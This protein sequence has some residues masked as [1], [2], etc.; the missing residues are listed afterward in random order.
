MADFFSLRLLWHCPSGE[1][2]AQSS[3][4]K[5]IAQAASQAQQNKA[6]A[7]D[8]PKKNAKLPAAPLIGARLANAQYNFSF[9]PSA[10]KGVTL[11][12]PTSLQFGP[13]GHLYVSQQNGLIKDLTIRRNA[14]ND[15]TVTSSKDIDLINLIPNHDDNGQANPGVTVRQ[16][17][18]ILVKGTAS[19]P[20]IYVS[21]SDSRV[22]GPG[23]DLNLDTN[24]GIVSKLTRSGTTWSKVDLVRGLPRSEENHA[25]NGMQLD[26]N[27]LYLAVGGHTN[28]GSPSVNFAFTPEYALSA[29]ILSIDLDAIS[30][31][32]VKGTGN[33]SYIYDLPTLDDPDRANLADG[34]DPFD[35]FGGNDG[36][37]QAKIVVGGPVQI[38]SPGYRN[39]YD[40]VITRARRMY[41]ID[42]GANQYWGGYPENEGGGNATN[43]YVN[44]EPGSSGPTATEDIVN[45]LDNLHYIGDLA[46]YTAGSY[47]GGHPAPT[48]ANPTNAGLYTHDGT[49]GVFRISKIGPNPLPADWPPVSKANPIEGDY[50][51]PGSA[52]S[53]SLLTFES[54]TNGLCEYTA[55]NFGGALQ[56]S[57][58]ACSFNGDIVKISLT[59]DGTNVT[60]PYNPANKV[61]SDLPFASGFGSTPL[62]ITAQGDGEIFAGSVWAATYG[63]SAI[64]IFEPQDFLTCSGAYNS[65]DDDQDGYTNADEID[66]GTQP[67][68]AASRPTDSNNNNISDLNDNDDD[69]DGLAD[70]KDFFALDKDN[71]LS[72]NLPIKYELL[73]NGPGGLFTVG[74]TGLMSNGDSTYS[75]LYTYGDIIGGGTAGIFTVVKVTA[76]DALGNLNTQENGFQVGIKSTGSPFT[77]QG[78]MLGP[79]FNDKVPQGFQSQG[80]YLGTGD[81]DNYLKIALAANG[82]TGGLQIVHENAGVPVTTNFVLPGGVPST[83][84][85][86]FFSVNPAAGTVQPK[87]AIN[88]SNTVTNLGSPIQLSGALLATVQSGKAYAVGLIATSRGASIFGAGWDFIY[89]T[90]DQV[91]ALGTWSPVTPTTGAFT[92]RQENAYVGAGNKFYLLGGRGTLPVQEYNPAAKAWATKAAP[93]VELSHFQAVTLD[94]LIYAMGAMNG[95]Y[96]REVPVPNV[97]IYNPTSDKW[98]VGGTIPQA[99][100][101]GS[102]GTVTYKNKIYMVGGIIDGHWAGWVPWFDEYDPATNT[103]KALPNAPR[104]RDHFNATIIDDKLYLVGGR[105]SSVSTNQP[106][107]LTVPEVDV[108]DFTTGQWAT[109]PSA[110]NLPT[111]RAGAATAVLGTELLVIGGESSLAAAHK[112]THS[113]D[114]TTNT[115]RR[116]ADLQTGRHSTQAIVNN[117]GVYLAAGATTQGGT[118]LASTQEAFYFF[119]PTTPGGTALAPSKLTAVAT[120]DYGFPAPNTDSTR[121]VK[122]TNTDG[123]QAILVSAV[124]LSGSSSFSYTTPSIL[125]VVV[126]VGKT[127]DV[128][129]KFNTAVG[130]TQTAKLVVSHSGVGDTTVTAIKGGGRTSPLFRVR[131][132]GDALTTSIGAFSAD[133]NFNGNGNTYY[134]GNQIGGTED[135]ALYQ[136]ERYGTAFGYAFPV[137]SGQQYRV[138]L[139]FAE[140]YATTIGQRVFDVSLEG[141][142]VLDNYDIFK[143]VGTNVAT[144][145]TFT[146]TVADDVLNLNF[147]SLAADGGVDN[148]K[149]SAIEVYR[150]SQGSNQPPVANAGPDK[151]VSLPATST[152]LS[153]SGTD[154]DGTITTYAWTQ[155]SGPNT[156]IFS[157]KNAAAPTLN[158][159][160]AGSYVFSLIVTDNE[161]QASTADQ[162]T[163]KVNPAPAGVAAIYR[164]HAGGPA[165]STSIGAFDSDQY[166]SGG[167]AAD[168]GN[169]IAGTTDDALYQTER[170]GAM[171][172]ALPVSNG[173]YTVKLHFAEV[174]WSAPGQR[175]FDVTAEGTKVLSAYDI[176]KKVGQ[177]TATTETFTATVTDG[178]L[179]LVFAKGATGADEPKVSAIEVLTTGTANAAPVANAGPDKST[180][181]PTNSVILNGSGTDSDGTVASYAWTQVS[182]PNTAVFSSKTVA[183]PTVSGLIA[184]NYVFSLIVTDNAG[185]ASTADQVAVTVS[186]AANAAPVANAGP[187]KTVTLP[188]NTTTLAGSGTD[189]DGSITTYAWTQVSGP[190]TATFSSTTIAAPTVSGL[191]AGAYVFSLIVTDNAGLASTA[192]QV[193]I[194]VNS[195]ANAAP[196]ANAGPDKT[197]TLPTN[198]VLLTGSGTDADGSV[199]TYAWTQ[200]S[201][202]NTAVFTSKTVAQPTVSG[203]VAGPYVFSLIVTDNAG[204]ASTADQVTVTVNSVA[205]AAP[206]A[207]AGAD[208]T[209]TL[210]TN[211]TTLNGSGT[212]SDGSIT[213]YAWTQ[214]SGPNTAVFSS[215][216]VAAP[217]VSG[218]VAGAY[219]FSLVVTDNAGLASTADQ[220]T[221]TVNSVAN[222]TPVAN[223]GPDKAITLPTNSTTLN[224]S[225]TDDGT[226]TTYAWTQVSGPNTAVFTSKATAAPTVS[227][228]IAGNYV[229]SLVV[230]DNAGLA[231]A[232]DQVNVTVSPAPTGGGTPVYRINAGGPAVT[233][234]GM[235]FAADN[236]YVSGGF[237]SGGGSAIAGTV[238][239]VLYQTERWGTMSYNLPVTNG[240][241]TVKLHFA[242]VYWGGAGQRVFDVSAEGTK[243]L[244]AYDIFKKV[245]QNTATIETLTVTVTD[246]TLNIAFAKGATGA[247]EPKVSA[248]EVLTTTGP[249]NTAP[250]ANAGPDKTITLPTSNVTLTGSGTDA[251][252]NPITYAWTQVSG[253]STAVFTSK[254]V[255]QPAVSNLVAG[256]YVFS[257]IVTDNAGLASPADQVTVTVNAA[258]NVMPVANAGPDKVITLPTSSTVL[259]G[260]GT[261]SDGSVTTYAWTQVSGPNTA[262]FT[263]KATAAPTVSGLVAGNYVFSLVVTDNAGLASA[264]D[265]VNVTVSPAP[266]G[267]GTPVYRINAGGPA[268]TTSGMAFA[269]DNQYVSGGFPS[270]GGSAIA[271]TV[272]DVLYQT[273]RWGTMS[274][275]LPVTNGTYTVKLHFAEVYW[276]G[277]GQ[278]VFDVS[279]EGTKVLTAYDIFKKVGQNT[280]TIETLTVTVTDGTLNIAFAKGATGA[281]EPK[282]SAIE[283]LTTTS[284]AA[285]TSAGT[286]SGTLANASTAQA[287][288][289]QGTTV[290]NLSELVEV[291]PNPSTDGRYQVQ[292]PAAFQGE[293]SYSLISAQGQLVRQG[294]VTPTGSTLVLDFS[295][296]MPAEG[297]YHLQLTTDKAHAKVKLL[298]H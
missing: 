217:S 206:V 283:V 79:F 179:T 126:P 44:G 35:P 209:I 102:A 47:Y 160:V 239:D 96:P 113:L 250:V 232:A 132:G 295:Q 196:V 237:P 115:W 185:L 227:G 43:N 261:D 110:S 144:T 85:D 198:S 127:L 78:R 112:E 277:A 288:T 262:V 263:S 75:D 69:S 211:T 241:Y 175:V 42:N 48:R 149:V 139:H 243:V 104:S 219:I 140:I 256:A 143:K 194:T 65:N 25:V 290:A 205:N 151:T 97:Y 37:N 188:T 204:L 50:Q 90:A 161:N 13:D 167:T 5:G 59:A 276:G 94:G 267:G 224:G 18:G 201:G 83:S 294:K 159:L 54:S 58:L 148:A 123:N 170:W 258:A 155:V 136:A 93:P 64:T 257:L 251:E 272:D 182:G 114:V 124:T 24:S 255:A 150:L 101:R 282:V 60:N 128:P 73:N 129:V 147:S 284:T 297:I 187:D 67:C 281:D 120:L 4:N 268:V 195:V 116:V 190:N 274:Y 49:S 17:T 153:G 226:I 55:S 249:A 275:N 16:V 266:T 119:A 135:D 218:L 244:T 225:G 53:K 88:G 172:Y 271:G 2:L 278:R 296:Q 92:N 121:V 289:V 259:N 11:E 265:Q 32:P 202:P 212:D 285:R 89:V 233:T 180:M 81:Q 1:V 178:A 22:G 27:K 38:F 216:S 287:A 222:A 87:Y 168:T 142:K 15:Y 252:G 134:A 36:L 270:G 163:V 51:A 68:S 215:T 246:G 30:K 174:Y 169:P 70:N 122:L 10:L 71:G 138:V 248:I 82:G 292:L 280:A 125:P 184:G 46:T 177:N 3:G 229:F 254:T 41:T 207:N 286:S 57:L 171:T 14:A 162:I 197:I 176:V 95:T 52:A 45:N 20:I 12:N 98:K 7:N 260:S 141:N 107:E 34:S 108:Y 39:P 72:T 214:V 269:A 242:E 183:V 186:A 105:R 100:R 166:F 118:S 62:D 99:R 117:S 8:K 231:S 84:I 210:P 245:G 66:N 133:Q 264:A 28:A 191:V 230:T 137:S 199:A 111:P 238:D 157:S 63:A 152:S 273:E 240:T 234:S 109:L 74:F 77:V 192:D 21:S 103:W 31:L 181:L 279:A 40:I 213:T 154:S 221:V 158:N 131:A 91:T 193:T 80:I 200:V 228:L 156:A 253:P 203:L 130:G 298:R 173:T 165:V 61:N 220:V 56:G 9:S 247:D 76:G 208:K 106:V 26:N 145:E 223:A 291:Y 33:N 6:A 23:G 19:S 189:T 164:I 293:I 86:F 29:A 146:T 236:Q 235:A